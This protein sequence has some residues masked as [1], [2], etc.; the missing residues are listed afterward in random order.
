MGKRIIKEECIEFCNRKFFGDNNPHYYDCECHNGY[1]IGTLC[2]CGENTGLE[3]KKIT[4]K[5]PIRKDILKN[6]D[7]AKYV[8]EYRGL[9]DLDYKDITYG[10]IMMVYGEIVK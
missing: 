9:H 8:L 1:A 5:Y 10:D 4:I 2:D 3:P 6:R 7:K